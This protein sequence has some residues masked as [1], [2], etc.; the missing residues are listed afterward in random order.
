MCRIAEGILRHHQDDRWFHNS[1]AFQR[2][3]WAVQQ[4]LILLLP[5]DRGFRPHFL[6]HVLVE[7]LLDAKLIS[8]DPL[9]LDKYYSA[10]AAVDANSVQRGVNLIARHKTDRL[11][12]VI[13]MFLR[14]RFL[15]DYM[16]DDRILLRLNQVMSRVRL[17]RLPGKLRSCLPQLR[18][19]VGDARE[20]LLP[21][22]GAIDHGRQGIQPK[23]T[24][25]FSRTE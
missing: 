2:A 4:E 7:M 16:D 6:A 15:A 25:A 23:I 18:A 3:T 14:E 19:I 10:I 20:S 12:W 1:H 17:P 11:V 13:E 9:L 5:N 8:D 21:V 22:A 24:D